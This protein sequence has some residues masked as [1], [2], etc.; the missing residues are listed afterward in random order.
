M[1]VGGYQK[2]TGLGQSESYAL[3]LGVTRF[4]PCKLQNT[5]HRSMP[6]YTSKTTQAF[7][8]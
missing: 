5:Q 1:D 2:Y 6:F 3:P 8:Q 4:E 7:V